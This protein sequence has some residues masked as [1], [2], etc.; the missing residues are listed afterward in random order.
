MTLRQGDTY[1]GNA[2]LKATNTPI[3]FTPDQVQE[4]MKCVEDPIYFIEKYI[5]IV[6]LDRGLQPFI[7]WNF[8]KDMLR[9][10]H[11]NRFVICK[12]PRQSGK[13]TTVLA[14]AL[15]YILFNPTV[16]V[17]LLANKL[18]TARELLGRLKT[19]Y[20]YLTGRC[21]CRPRCCQASCVALHRCG[22]LV[23]HRHSK[24]Q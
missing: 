19:A 1:L 11:S 10:V 13:S 9:T 22:V 17:A 21:R 7:P 3:E 8:Q 15:W 5:R 20:E 4:Y 18:Q 14:Y 23:F 12:Y 6:T 16:N 24:K 2:N